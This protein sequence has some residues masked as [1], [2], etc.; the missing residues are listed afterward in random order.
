MR[1]EALSLRLGRDSQRNRRCGIVQRR[2]G[3]RMRDRRSRRRQLEKCAAG[4]ANVAAGK[5]CTAVPILGG[6]AAGLPAP[7]R[8]LGAQPAMLLVRQRELAPG[9]PGRSS[10]SPQQVVDCLPRRPARRGLHA[11]RMPCVLVHRGPGL[12]LHHVHCGRRRS[13]TWLPAPPAAPQPER[14]QPHHR[15]RPQGSAMNPRWPPSNNRP[16]PLRAATRAPGR[17]RQTG[18]S[19]CRA[20]TRAPCWAPGVA[21]AGRPGRITVLP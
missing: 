8:H 20:E 21:M 1:L 10:W 3:D 4:A 6:Q 18:C 9:T 14:P 11:R 17:L 13:R 7:S 15:L 5:P 2:G 19:P 16:N 12:R